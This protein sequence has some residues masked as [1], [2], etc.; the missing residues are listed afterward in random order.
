MKKTG[1]TRRQM[2]AAMATSTVGG[3]VAKGSVIKQRKK[4]HHH[5]TKSRVVT[6]DAQVSRDGQRSV[7]VPISI[8]VA[9]WT[10]PLE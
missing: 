10:E 4:V 8:D 3:V 2:L 5:F 1:L 9:K 7:T 6:F